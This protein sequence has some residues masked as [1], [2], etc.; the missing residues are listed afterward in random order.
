VTRL[1]W[2][3]DRL[4]SAATS[5]RL[6]RLLKLAGLADSGGEAKQLLAAERV[7]VTAR[8]WRTPAAV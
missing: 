6:G 5:I 2:P 8:S 1:H 3:Y 4:R 7:I